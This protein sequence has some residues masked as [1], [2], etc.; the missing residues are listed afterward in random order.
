MSYQNAEAITLP[1]LTGA[2]VDI[3]KGRVLTL[4]SVGATLPAALEDVYVGVSSE[5]SDVSES[6][7]GNAEGVISA[8]AMKP[9]TAVEIEA[10]AAI[11]LGQ[12]IIVGNDGR[13]MPGVVGATATT[14]I[15]DYIEIGVAQSAAGAAGE[16]VTVMLGMGNSLT[17]A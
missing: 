16:F 10:G 3:P 6:L 4:T 9:G 12:A 7:L 15:G 2:T 11:T 8:V 13:A 14:P 1:I 17:T 5:A